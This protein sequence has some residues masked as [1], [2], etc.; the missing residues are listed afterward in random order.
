ME[1]MREQFQWFVEILSQNQSRGWGTAYRDFADVLL[2][3]RAVEGLGMAE[4]RNSR[5][6]NGVFRSSMG[7]YALTLPQFV[8]EMGLG[9]S[10]ATWRN[11][12]TMYFRIMSLY[13]YAQHNGGACFRFPPHRLA[14]EA[15]SRWVENQDV[16]LSANW[17]TIRY[18]NTE[19]RPL[20]RDMLQEALK[21]KRLNWVFCT[22][23]AESECILPGGVEH[24]EEL[25][26]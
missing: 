7:D 14:W 12:L 4:R 10:A 9:H 8:E 21:G 24:A 3:L 1:E 2:L 23:N 22:F 26:G 5:I 17:M 6:S 11:K 20:V 19:L 15:L 16:F 18:G 13:S 25:D